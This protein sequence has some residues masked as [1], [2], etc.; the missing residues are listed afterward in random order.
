MNSSRRVTIRF[1]RSNCVLLLTRECPDGWRVS[2]EGVDLGVLRCE[3]GMWRDK[4]SRHILTTRWSYG[5]HEFTR[6]KHA[7]LN[8]AFDNP[9]FWDA[10][11]ASIMR[12][13]LG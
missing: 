6:R 12:A 4:E 5:K 7:L 9:K 3:R 13:V 2:F 1:D 10:L 11:Q 8:M